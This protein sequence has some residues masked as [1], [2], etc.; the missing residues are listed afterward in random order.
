MNSLAQERVGAGM[1]VAG[2]VKGI[3]IRIMN[4]RNDYEESTESMN[5]SMNECNAPI[6][7]N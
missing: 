4:S 6:T 2:A 7:N 5:E 3:L 1:T